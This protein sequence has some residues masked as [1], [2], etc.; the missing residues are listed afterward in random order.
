MMRE[1]QEIHDQ[2]ALEEN[3]LA[4]RIYTCTE[5]TSTLLYLFYKNGQRLHGETVEEILISIH[6][7]EQD[8]QT[9]LLHT[10]IEKTIATSLYDNSEKPFSADEHLPDDK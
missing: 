8:L 7:I 1:V 9:E 4:Q 10:R 2:F 6:Q 3:V 5:I